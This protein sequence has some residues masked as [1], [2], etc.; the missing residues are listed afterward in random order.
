MNLSLLK[1][2]ILMLYLVIVIILIQDM[3][4]KEIWNLILLVE[5]LIIQ[6][7]L[8]R[9]GCIEIQFPTWSLLYIITIITIIL[10]GT[11]THL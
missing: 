10:M 7:I 6:L 5:E 2:L 11:I 4:N 8:G 1:L 3:F 9:L